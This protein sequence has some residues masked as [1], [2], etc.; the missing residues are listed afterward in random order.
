MPN[1]T[2]R[3]SVCL[4]ASALAMSAAAGEPPV[5]TLPNDALGAPFWAV[6]REVAAL[7]QP[8]IEEEFF[9]EGTATVY[10]YRTLP[11][12]RGDIEPIPGQTDLPYKTR[13][14]VRRP[15]DPADFNGTVVIEWM[16]STS[17]FDV[18]AVW[19]TS[20]E[21]FARKGIV[22]VGWTNSNQ[23]LA[24]LLGGCQP[25]P[26]L[27]ATCQTRYLDLLISENGQAYE[28]GNQLAR[29]LRNPATSPLPE[30]YVVQRI[31]H[32]GQSQQGGSIIT[33]A[34]AFHDPDASDGYFVQTAG[35]A[36]TINGGVA[37]SAE[38]A[39]A[40]P[41]CTPSLEGDQ[42]LVR[43]DLPVPVYRMQTETDLAV[44]GVLTGGTRQEDGDGFR[45][46]E[47]AGSAHTTVHKVELFGLPI[48][49]ET[50]CA[51]TLNSLADGPVFGAFVVNALWE[52]LEVQLE[53]G[54]AAPRGEP[55]KTVGDTIARDV[56]GNALGGVR[57]PELDVPVARYGPSATVSPDLPGFIPLDLANFFCFLTGTTTPFSESLLELLY[58]TRNNFV[59]PYFAATDALVEA[60]FLLP[61]DAALLK[62]RAVPE[63]HGAWVAA[64]V[65]GVLGWHR[66]LRARR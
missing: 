21:Y 62:A 3:V 38:G 8:Y 50:F 42:R 18:A 63:A 64:V 24:F 25:V 9:L 39:P 10:N 34:S 65:L 55:I 17:G 6:V 15:A 7:E 2:P 36:R 37:C 28:I 47:L 13:F 29:L 20:A 56:F 40:F 46:Y 26:L 57:L 58:P 51:E 5:V 27:P 41:N 23:S 33:Y 22:Y 11:P 16:N 49:I 52:N 35:T 43:T 1:R 12:V 14:V 53:D 45:Y 59:D 66:R 44:L 32:S 30:D 19:D 60:R 48:A 4:L 31:F 54:I 61:E